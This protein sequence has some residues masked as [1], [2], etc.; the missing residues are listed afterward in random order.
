M[1]C[2]LS[3]YSLYGQV[4]FE[5]DFETGSFKDGWIPRENITG[6]DGSV[7]VTPNTKFAGQYGAFIGKSSDGGFTTNALDLTLDLSGQSQVEL[8]FQLYNNFDETQLQDGL[9]FSNDGGVN[10]TKVYDFDPT[11]WCIGW[12][13]FPPFD[14]DKLA[15]ANGL[16]LTS[17]FVIRIQQHGEDDFVGGSRA[18]EDGFYIDDVVVRVPTTEYATLP[19]EDNFETGEFKTAWSWSHP[20]STVLNSDEIKPTGQVGIG[21][22]NPYNST[23]SAFMGK[24]CDDGFTTN[25]LDLHLDLSGQSQVELSFQLYNNFDETQLQDGLYFSNDGGVNFTKVYDFDPTAWCI[26]WAQF[27]PFDIDKLATANGLTLTSQFVIRIQQHG[28]DDF[29]GGSRASED[30]FYIDDVVVRVPTTEYATL[31]FEDNFETGE[32][33][34]AW[35]WSHP[36]STVLNSDEIKPTGQVGIGTG[37]PYNSTY[38]AFMGKRCDDGFTTNALDLHLDLSGQS[39]VELS[40][41]FY[42]NFD[43]TQP[44][45]GLYF[46]NDGGV[47]FTK[48]YDFDPTN[49]DISFQLFSLNLNELIQNVGLTLSDSSVIRIQQHGEDDFVGG[50][51]ASEDGFYIDNVVVQNTKLPF[52]TSFSP[53]TAPIGRQ[54]TLTGINLNTVTVRAVCRSRSGHRRGS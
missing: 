34:T 46:S 20:D 35:S 2:F 38:S 33:K 36:D 40:F 6:T 27:P 10:F 31:P 29:V 21:T 28:E 42:N 7:G 17:Q 49:Y 30:G 24:R 15:T 16:T 48:V 14:I 5:D 41:Q 25:A 26:G 1:L 45:D 11:A 39:Q 22:G 50:S 4:I 37:N 12:A 44:Q 32:F 8:S 52:I 3:T 47:N 9:Y 19:F 18:S 54:I 53:G 51:R 43:E 13:Q 23:Y